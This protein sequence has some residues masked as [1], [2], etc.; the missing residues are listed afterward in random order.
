MVK[1][2]FNQFLALLILSILF[3]TCTPKVKQEVRESGPSI[4]ILLSTIADK[5]SLTFSG[6]YILPDMNSENEIK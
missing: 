5:D 4:R 1:H 3:F 2:I 6:T